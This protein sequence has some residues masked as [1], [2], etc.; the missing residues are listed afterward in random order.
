MADNCNDATHSEPQELAAH[1]PI[2]STTTDGANLI[3]LP[4]E[5]YESIVDKVVDWGT[6]RAFALVCHLFAQLAQKLIFSSISLTRPITW[7]IAQRIG[8]YVWSPIHFLQILSSSP[9]LAGYVKS[10]KLSDGAHL[11]FYHEELSWIRSDNVV[12]QILPRL[13]NLELLSLEGNPQGSSL[14]FRAWGENLRAGILERCSSERLVMIHL[15]H[16]RNI[17]LN[18]LALAPRLE[19]LALRNV[20]FV[21]KFDRYTVGD[22]FDLQGY[23]K[24]KERFPPAQLKHFSVMWM[25]SKEWRTFYPWLASHLDLTHIKT[26]DLYIDFENAREE[27]IEAGLQAISNILRGCSATLETLGFLMPE[28]GIFLFYSFNRMNFSHSYTFLVL[29]KP[30]RSCQIDPCPSNSI[31]IQCQLSVASISSAAS[32]TNANT[33]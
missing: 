33:W 25:R 10:L 9:H 20:L 23:T 14:N 19:T 11:Q 3:S 17:P 8:S 6:L 18:L 7:F 28:L 13:I 32:G 1:A 27:I 31:Y 4:T 22:V 26:L 5:I 16:V 29:Q 24:L 12:H 2:P 21:S 30:P 15:A